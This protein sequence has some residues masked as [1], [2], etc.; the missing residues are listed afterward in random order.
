VCRTGYRRAGGDSAA[1]HKSCGTIIENHF[2]RRAAVFDV[3][4]VASYGTAVRA[5][6]DVLKTTVYERRGGHA[7]RFNDL[8][9]DDKT[10]C[11]LSFQWPLQG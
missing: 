8:F 1:R 4:R 5:A 9:T 11:R 7:V 3:L 2:A 10:T 6:I